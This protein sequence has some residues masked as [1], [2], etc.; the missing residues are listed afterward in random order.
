MTIEELVG[1]GRSA[2]LLAEAV[3]AT[4]VDSLVIVVGRATA[5]ICL[6]F[7]RHLNRGAPGGWLLGAMLELCGSGGRVVPSL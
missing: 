1:A 3:A 6:R 2:C 4:S 5:L 7:P